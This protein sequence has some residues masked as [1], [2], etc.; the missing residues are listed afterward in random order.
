MSDKDKIELKMGDIES[1]THIVDLAVRRG[2]FQA[3]ELSAIGKTYDT[4]TT[5]LKN[6]KEAQET[7]QTE[8]QS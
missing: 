7:P 4:V 5:F 6:A 3:S 2:A 8:V 1:L